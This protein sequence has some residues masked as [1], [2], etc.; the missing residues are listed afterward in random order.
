M[1]SPLEI[2]LKEEKTPT[3]W[4]RFLHW[5]NAESAA[6]KAPVQQLPKTGTNTDILLSKTQKQELK[7]AV[8]SPLV[9]RLSA[10][11]DTSFL[12]KSDS[13]DNSNL[14]I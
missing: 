7:K 4:E 2:K 6:A 1:S 8:E 14:I 3:I 5:L 10:S 13:N 11:S 12:R 9:D